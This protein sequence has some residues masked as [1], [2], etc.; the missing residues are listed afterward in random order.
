MECKRIII[1]FE[2]LHQHVQFR[3][4][5]A[6]GINNPIDFKRFF[7]LNPI[8]FTEFCK[9]NNKNKKYYGKNTILDNESIVSSIR[10]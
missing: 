2:D 4:A 8:I 7:K 9:N 5:K 3:I 10:P 1:L 6:H